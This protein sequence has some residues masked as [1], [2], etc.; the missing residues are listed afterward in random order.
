MDKE[1]NELVK[2]NIIASFKEEYRAILL[3]SFV[4]KYEEWQGKMRYVNEVVSDTDSSILPYDYDEF[5]KIIIDVT[6][7]CMD[8]NVDFE[9][10]FLSQSEYLEISKEAAKEQDDEGMRQA[11]DQAMLEEINKKFMNN[12][13][14]VVNHEQF[15]EAA[16][17]KLKEKYNA[18]EAR[19]S[20][21][22]KIAEGI[23][24]EYE[25]KRKS[26]E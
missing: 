1:E 10:L 6:N 5:C 21:S 16:R 2:S 19:L 24:K 18:I 17:Y 7:N 26:H 13:A 25:S 15:K 4:E 3:E 12:F 9:K 11:R 14:V 20:N 23:L 8:K 22:L